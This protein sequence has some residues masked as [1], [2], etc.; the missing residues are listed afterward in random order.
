MIVFFQV[1]K[2]MNTTINCVLGFYVKLGSKKE[3]DIVI[4]MVDTVLDHL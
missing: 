4:A 2:I 3:K 1:K